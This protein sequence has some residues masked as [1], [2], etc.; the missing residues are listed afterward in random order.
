MS[1][2]ELVD[3]T[4]NNACAVLLKQDYPSFLSPLPPR[5]PLAL[6]AAPFPLRLAPLTPLST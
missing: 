4:F 1:C 2:M 5:R 6:E 3:A